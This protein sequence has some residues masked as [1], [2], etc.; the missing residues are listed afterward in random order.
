M[1]F[2]GSV[3]SFCLAKKERKVSKKNT[4]TI[5][6]FIFYTFISFLLSCA[7]KRKETNQRKEN[8]ALSIETASC[9]NKDFA[10]TS[11]GQNLLKT[12]LFLAKFHQG[13]APNPLRLTK[14]AVTF[15]LSG[16][17]EIGRARRV[18]APVV[19]WAKRMRAHHHK[20][21]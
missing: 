4:V 8:Q 9:F 15:F 16:G 13:F 6:L 1:N 20:A 7:S 14:Q 19:G 2:F 10:T 12:Q 11:C 21:A 3:F 18:K 5:N 17:S